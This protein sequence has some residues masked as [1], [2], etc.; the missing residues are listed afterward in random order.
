MWQWENAKSHSEKLHEILK[1]IR[2]FNAGEV[3]DIFGSFHHHIP[4]GKTMKLNVNYDS[5]DLSNI[6]SRRQHF[7]ENRNKK[8]KL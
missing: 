3:F 6:K 8:R 7:S 2:N 1:C 5:I 4:Q